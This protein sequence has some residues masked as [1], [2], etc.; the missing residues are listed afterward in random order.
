M[1]QATLDKVREHARE[2]AL[3]RSVAELLEWNKISAAQYLQPGQRLVLYVD[4]T[5]QSG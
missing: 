2:S 4:V 3:L 1:S 5:K